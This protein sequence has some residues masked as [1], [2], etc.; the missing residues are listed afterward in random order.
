MNLKNNYDESNPLSIENY[1]KGLI[2]KTFEEVLYNYIFED[3]T[4]YE[5]IKEMFNNPRRK[6]SLGNLIEEFYFGY[7]PNNSPEPDFPKAGVEL[8]VTPYEK[9]K[10]GKIRAGERLV[11]GMIPNDEPI[12]DNFFESSAYKKMKLILLVLYYRNKD[13]ERIQHPIHYSQLVSIHSDALRKDLEIIKSDYK[14]IATKIREG[15]AH[16]LSEADTMYLGAA[17]KGASAESS[18]QPQFYNKLESAKR[19]AFSL[20]QSYMTVFINEYIFG[21]QKT[22]DDIVEEAVTNETFEN[23][24]LSKI[25]KYKHYTTEHLQDILGIVDS[26]AKHRYSKIVFNL[27][28]VKSTN[29]EEF[30]K[31]NTQVK[32]IRIEE[33]GSIKESV[34]FPA[35]SFKEFAEE[36]WESSLVYNFFSETRFLFVIFRCIDGVYRLNDAF[37]WN[38]PYS[39]LNVE[40]KEDWTR[41]Q[42]VVREGVKFKVSGSRVYNN[43]PNYSETTIFHL[44]PKSNNSAYNVP[45]KCLHRGDIEKDAD[46]LPNGD[47]MTRQC[48]WLSKK[49][50]LG[51][52]KKSK[53]G[54]VKP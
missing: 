23:I 42:Q 8:K 11:L 35:I 36:E 20:K 21:E 30:E 15:K 32:T 34:S 53:K 52:I 49:Y 33:D 25:A 14:I 43:L 10:T 37:F 24:V 7:I 18:N 13:I 45:D 41:A 38:M 12:S 4:K 48:F 28:N 22:Y 17:T 2:G 19:R 46:I 1:S 31:S 9:T 16:E 5:V 6:G 39:D 50:L 29:A 26:N 54:L 47:M 44:R 3:D 27:L 51:Q 40:G